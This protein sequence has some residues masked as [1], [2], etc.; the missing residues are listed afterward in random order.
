MDQ[1]S[2]SDDDSG[3]QEVGASVPHWVSTAR[4]WI[5]T[6]RQGARGERSGGG[7]LNGQGEPQTEG[8]QSSMSVNEVCSRISW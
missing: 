7:L 2:G 1:S 6:E 4:S 8:P 3:Q 5:G